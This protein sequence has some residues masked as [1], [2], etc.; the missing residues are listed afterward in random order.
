MS[1]LRPC[2]E[3]PFAA[4]RRAGALLAEL[5]AA[6]A[7]FSIVLAIVVPVIGSVTAIRE[8]T[9][10]RQLARIELANVMER[11]AAAHRA[12]QTLR[13]SADDVRI[14]TELQALLPDAALAVDIAAA[15]DLSGCSRV[16]ARLTWR[17]ESGRPAAPAELTAFFIER[18][19]QESAP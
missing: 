14:S 13:A 5:A 6:V 19:A 7:L 2:P 18:A 1:Q 3:C 12:G 4:R 15:D 9:H 11:L 10:R 8:E 16:A 17:N